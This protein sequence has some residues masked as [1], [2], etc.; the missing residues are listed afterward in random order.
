M[1]AT[2][3]P[4]ARYTAERSAIPVAFVSTSSARDA[5]HLG[6]RA[7]LIAHEAQRHHRNRVAEGAAG[8]GSASA[9]ATE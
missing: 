4:E 6:E 9:L 3:L 5:Q 1:R 7:P 8:D 2:A